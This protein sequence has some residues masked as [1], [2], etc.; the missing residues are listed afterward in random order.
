MADTEPTDRELEALKVLWKRGEATVRQVYD[1]LNSAGE[2]LAYTT[3]LSLFQVME[4]KGLVTHRQEGKAY[5][6]LP[7]VEQRKTFRQ[8]ASKFLDRVFDGAVDEYLVH[9]IEGKRLT[10][11]ELDQLEAMIAKARVS[12]RRK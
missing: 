3:V 4:Q 2:P 10:S 6:Y 12:K 5:I 9:A 7:L 8:I 11:A 1:D